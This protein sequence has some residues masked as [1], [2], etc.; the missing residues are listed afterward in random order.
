MTTNADITLYHA[1]YDSVQRLN[2]YK[3][4]YYP[5]VSW[6]CDSKAT[7]TDRGLQAA[8][9][10]KVR[11][12]TTEA[13]ELAKGDKLVKGKCGDATPPMERAFTVLSFSDNRRG[14]LPH[15]RIHAE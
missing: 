13:V 10:V 5:A 7:V 12:P 15:W 9:V 3:A 11:I 6:Y 2:V 14:N 1:E 8:D 4:T